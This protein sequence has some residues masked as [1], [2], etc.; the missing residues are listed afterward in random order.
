[1]S[2]MLGFL[3]DKHSALI[4]KMLEMNQQRQKV[5]S[6]NL[7]NANTPGYTRRALSF[8]KELET[9]LETGGKQAIQSLETTVSK[10]QSNAPRP[11]GNNVVVAEELNHLMQNGLHHRLMTRIYSTRGNI[12][13]MAV[14]SGGK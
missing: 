6:N 10:D 11:D 8:E 9:V 5:I 1:M 13:K 2:E 7:A 4:S 14:H 12:L 3:T